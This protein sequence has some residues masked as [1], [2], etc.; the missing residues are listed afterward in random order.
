MSQGATR[1]ANDDRLLRDPSPSPA[2]QLPHQPA[3]S[4]RPP[5]AAAAEPPA[6]D[7][8]R[9]STVSLAQDT[10]PFLND[11][12]RFDYT[13]DTCPAPAAAA[14]KAPRPPISREPDATPGMQPSHASSRPLDHSKTFY[15]KW[16]MALGNC[17]GF[18]GQVGR[19]QTPEGL[20]LTKVPWTLYLSCFLLF[21]VVC[22]FP[23]ASAAQTPWCLSRKVDLALVGSRCKRSYANACF[24]EGFVG[25][26]SSFG[27]YYKTVDPGLTTMNVL[28]EEIKMVDVRIQVRMRKQSR[29]WPAPWASADRRRRAFLLQITE[30]PRQD[31]MTKDNVCVSIEW[32]ACHGVFFFSTPLIHTNLPSKLLQLRGL[33]DCVRPHTWGIK[34]ESSERRDYGDDF[35]AELRE[36][37]ASAA[38]QKRIGESKII[39]ARAEVEGNSLFTLRPR[40]APNEANLNCRPDILNTKAAMQIRY[41][42]TLRDMSR[43]SGSKIIF[44]PLTD[45]DADDSKPHGM[46]GGGIPA[47]VQRSAIMDNVSKM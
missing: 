33:L 41:L 8:A 3:A 24:G 39:A 5:H 21:W 27:R 19:N 9:A 42:D 16:M 45:Q 38:T 37:L 34:V 30:I 18:F 15:E 47:G 46:A 43:S 2:P 35:G 14:A 32:V 36:S 12:I 4:H 17:M 7:G 26:I 44:M 29:Y 25:L 1:A 11:E 22:R 31:I 28:T 20:L 40:A 23:V 6:D 13:M 10:R